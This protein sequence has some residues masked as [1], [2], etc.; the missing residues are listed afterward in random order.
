M[1]TGDPSRM[2]ERMPF[3]G[4][5]DALTTLGEAVAA[6]RAGHST[7]TV[8][9][10]EPGIGKTRLLDELCRDAD[11]AGCIVM[12]GGCDEA[13]AGASHV[14]L[15]RAIEPHVRLM[16]S[17]IDRGERGACGGAHPHRT[18]ADRGPPGRG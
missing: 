1:R 15:G 11:A 14:A 3:I 9:V 6:A 12:R 18:V 8:V 7:S 10:G 2:D 17:E 13:I 5:G 16:A 4:R